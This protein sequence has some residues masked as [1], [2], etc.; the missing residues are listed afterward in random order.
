VAGRLR[1]VEARIDPEQIVDVWIFPPLRDLDD[2]SE[3]V[4]LSR[5]VPDGRRRL[6]TAGLRR[7]P[8][9]PPPAEEGTEEAE[10]AAA[11][12]GAPEGAAS[13]AP[14]HEVT[15]HGVVPAER[16]PRLLERFRRRI[17]EQHEPRHVAIQGSRARWEAL[18]PRPAGGEDGG[19]EGRGR[20]GEDVELDGADP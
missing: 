8:P 10:S 5:S 12:P 15:E 16:L 20:G 3:F 2:S 1:D 19:E 17:G 4:V 14:T 13:R 11:E 7:R 6:Y 9:E 18:V